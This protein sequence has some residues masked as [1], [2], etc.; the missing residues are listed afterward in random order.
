MK[1]GKEI[2]Y[3]TEIDVKWI[4]ERHQSGNMLMLMKITLQIPVNAEN[5]RLSIFFS[6]NLSKYTLVLITMMQL[7]LTVAVMITRLV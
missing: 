5:D 2:G 7:M 3:L 4:N 6:K 1:G